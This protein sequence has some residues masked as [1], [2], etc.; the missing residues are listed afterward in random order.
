M[1]ILY[2]LMATIIVYLIFLFLAILNIF[3]IRFL[4]H[5]DIAK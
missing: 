5:F 2:T 1:P 3:A 4:S